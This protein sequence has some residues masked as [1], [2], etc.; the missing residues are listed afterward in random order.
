VGVWIVRTRV[1][2]R[3][4]HMR[5][6]FLSLPASRMLMLMLIAAAADRNGS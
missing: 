1:F 5:S 4:V 2:E 3:L 6:W